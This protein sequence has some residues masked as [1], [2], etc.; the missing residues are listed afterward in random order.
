[1]TLMILSMNFILILRISHINSHIA[2]EAEKKEKNRY[3]PSM[4]YN[5][6]K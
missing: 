2:R 5:Y 1:M 3:I 6:R 4:K